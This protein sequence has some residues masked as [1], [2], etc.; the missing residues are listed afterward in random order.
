[1]PDHLYQE[2]MPALRKNIVQ[3]KDAAD[4]AGI[5]RILGQRFVFLWSYG[6]GASCKIVA[7]SHD[8]YVHPKRW[9]TQVL[10]VVAALRGGVDIQCSNDYVAGIR[11]YIGAATRII[12][13][14]EPLF[15]HGERANDLACSEQIK[16]PNLLV[17]K[18]GDERLVLL[19]NEDN[20]PLAV[21][22]ENKE[23]KAGQQAA[24]FERGGPVPN[25]ARIKLSIPAEDYAVV[26]IK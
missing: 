17:L 4:I 26:H 1:M 23:L 14:F 22:L 5:K 2:V 21:T 13:T 9:K 19:F 10:R 12:S 18:R 25:P 6:K 16:Y 15:W 11:Y 24:I 20:K 3:S 7:K 8:G